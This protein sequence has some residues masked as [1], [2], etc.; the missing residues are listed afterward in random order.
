VTITSVTEVIEVI[1]YQLWRGG[2]REANV[3]PTAA[4]SCCHSQVM[5]SDMH[6][7]RGTR[8]HPKGLQSPLEGTATPQG[9][10]DE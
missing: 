4:Y 6:P 7:T 2:F 10:R 8:I 3:A 9:D 5:S 1:G